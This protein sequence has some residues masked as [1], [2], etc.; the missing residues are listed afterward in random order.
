[1]D[2]YLLKPKHLLY[3]YTNL[4]KDFSNKIRFYHICF[5]HIWPKHQLDIIEIIVYYKIVKKEL[6]NKNKVYNNKKSAM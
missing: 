2:L 4:L 5:D 3:Y 1:M 6:F